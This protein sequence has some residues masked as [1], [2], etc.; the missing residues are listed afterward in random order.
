MNAAKEAKE[1]ID[2]HPVVKECLAKG[3]INFS[4]LARQIIEQRAL[5]SDDFDAVLV[6][7]RRHAGRLASGQDNESAILALFRKSRLEIKDKVCSAVLDKTAPFSF[8]V[9]LIEEI[10]ERQEPCHLIQGSRTFTLI[11]SQEFLPKIEKLFAGKIISVK[12]NLV[13]VVLRTGKEIESTPGVAAYL[14]GL[15]AEH[16][17][18]IV[19]TMSSW[20]ETLIVLEE[21]DLGKAM[22]IL[23]F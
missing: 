23:K 4:E 14:Y 12:K 3:L 13:Q 18:N 9:K 19:E 16:G 17:I 2:A 10:N 5:K 1:F 6:A 22:E 15:F 7:V 21:K 8:L 11:T 20:T